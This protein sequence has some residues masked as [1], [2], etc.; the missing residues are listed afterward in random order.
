MTLRS[1]NYGIY[2]MG[3]ANLVAEFI[4]PEKFTL[5]VL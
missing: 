4:S 1:L 3:I 5:S 2:G